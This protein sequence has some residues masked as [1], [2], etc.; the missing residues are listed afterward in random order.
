MADPLPSY[1]K[2]M[3]VEVNDDNSGILLFL[4][5]IYKI[6]NFTIVMTK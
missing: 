4:N 2:N 5:R 6:I 3:F 1:K